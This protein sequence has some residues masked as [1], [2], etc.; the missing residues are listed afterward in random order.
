MIAFYIILGLSALVMGWI[1]LLGFR[2]FI[3]ISTSFISSFWIIRTLGFLLPYYPNEI[4]ASQ[5]FT[6]D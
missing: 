3:I 6:I 2:K 5:L 1:S 4:Q